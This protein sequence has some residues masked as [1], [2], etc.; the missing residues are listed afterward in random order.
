MQDRLQSANSRHGPKTH[1][2]HQ[3]HHPTGRRRPRL[4]PLAKRRLG[5]FPGPKGPQRKERRD[6]ELRKVE[7]QRVVQI[8]FDEEMA[9]AEDGDARADEPG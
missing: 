8:P 2:R 5:I 7:L 1:G 4:W 6:S 3:Q 9:G